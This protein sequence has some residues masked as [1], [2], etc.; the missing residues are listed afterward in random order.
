ML[1]CLVELVKRMSVQDLSE[2]KIQQKKEENQP[3]NLGNV[4]GE[5]SNQL[6]EL[7]SA[8]AKDEAA[9]E[10]LDEGHSR[11]R[12]IRTLTKKGHRYQADLLLEKRKRAM[13]RM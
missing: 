9:L 1:E 13:S 11:S 6:M 7:Q 10:E 5:E 2:M 4:I 3:S 8:A 12:R